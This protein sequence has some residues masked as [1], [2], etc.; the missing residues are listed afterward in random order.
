MGGRATSI[1]FGLRCKAA[2]VRPSMGSVGDA[3]DNALCES[4]FATLECELLERERFPNQAEEKMKVF[5]RGLVQPAPE[6]Q[7]PRSALAHRLRKAGPEPSPFG[8][9]NDHNPDLVPIGNGVV[10]PFFTRQGR[11]PSL[12]CRPKQSAPR[13]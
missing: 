2:G 8:S 12:P 5:D 7:G 1:A 9:A 4:F 13:S 3:Y 6:A 10:E 11:K